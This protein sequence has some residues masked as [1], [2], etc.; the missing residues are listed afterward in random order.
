MKMIYSHIYS[1]SYSAI[2]YIRKYYQDIFNNTDGKNLS[3]YLE[4]IL[5]LDYKE[6]SQFLNPKIDFIMTKG[7]NP[8]DTDYE[9]AKLVYENF[10]NL[11][12]SQASDF[13]LWSGYAIEDEVYNYLK[14]R[15]KNDARTIL[16]RVSYRDAGKRGL[17]YHGIARL[18]WLSYLTYDDSKSD[19]YEL[20]KFT[21][22]YP[23]IMEKM[24]Y[25]NFSNSKNVRHGIIE[26]IKLF[27]DNGGKYTTSK[28][29]ELYKHISM[30]SGVNLLDIIPK[31]KIKAITLNFLIELE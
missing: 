18:W 15:W 8:K 31:E 22:E 23:H 7:I 12:E 10:K 11:T 1:L 17:L 28:I 26:G 6:K 20:T 4:S 2:E 13:R 29:D 9:N 24:I 14:Y 27:I 5:G 21:F 19:K 25:R 16:Y 30:I 3:T